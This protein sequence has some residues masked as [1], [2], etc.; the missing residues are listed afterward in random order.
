MHNRK[1]A[2][3]AWLTVVLLALTSIANAGPFPYVISYGDSLSDNGNLWAA[4]GHTTP[5]SPPYYFGRFS[6]GP[7]TVEQLTTDLGLSQ[8]HLLDFA[9]GGAVTGLGPVGGPPGMLTQLGYSLTLPAVQAVLP[10]ALVVVWGG[11]NDYFQNPAIS[12]TVP[13]G[14]LLGIISTLE[15]HGATHILVPGMPDLSLT[16]AYHGVSAAQTFS[17][18]F[19]ADL[20]AGLPSGVIYFNTYGFMHSVVGDPSAYGFTNVTMPCLVVP[21]PPALPIVCGQP[22]QYLFWDNVHPTTTADSFLAA[23]FEQ[24]VVPEPSTFLTVRLPGD[25]KSTVSARPWGAPP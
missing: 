4:T 7:V 20:L 16:P 6:D 12:P 13:V 18:Q 21:P 14:N 19:N 2:H 3:F 23:G 9:Y 22:D 24:A 8:T 11:A 25:A 1:I 15:A 17:Q 10:S 5:A